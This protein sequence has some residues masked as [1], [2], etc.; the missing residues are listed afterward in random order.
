LRSLVVLSPSQ[1]LKVNT[2][3]AKRPTLNASGL[4][5]DFGVGCLFA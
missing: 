5:F 3:A 4:S 1:R 2:T